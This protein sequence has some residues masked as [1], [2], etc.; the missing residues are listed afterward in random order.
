MTVLYAVRCKGWVNL[1]HALTGSRVAAG[2]R[3][4]EVADRV[5]ADGAAMGTAGSSCVRVAHV[6]AR[7]V[8]AVS[9]AACELIDE[10][11]GIIVAAVTALADHFAAHRAVV[12]I[13]AV[14]EPVAVVV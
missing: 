2:T 4:E 14:F 8:A 3:E 12:G 10:A 13:V 1:E 11:V 6:A 5:A 7:A 9:A